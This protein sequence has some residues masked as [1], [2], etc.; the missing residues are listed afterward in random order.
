M[1]DFVEEH[2]GDHGVEPI[3]K[4]LP[5]APST[6]YEQKAR[7]ADPDRLPPRLR[8][9]RGLCEEIQRVWDENFQVYGCCQ[10]ARPDR[11]AI[12]TTVQN[13]Y[14]ELGAGDHLDYVQHPD[15]HLLR[16]DLAAPFLEQYL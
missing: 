8:R 14:D 3:C 10:V 7:R 13:A 15:G 9:D 5:I 11:E 12:L 2:R 6:Y 4:V 1:V 16:W